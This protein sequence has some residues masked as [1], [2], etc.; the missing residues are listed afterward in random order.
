MI[1]MKKTIFLVIAVWMV[2]ILACNFSTSTANIS[3]AKMAKDAE[4]KQSTT[5]FAQDDTF[6][7]VLQVAN[8]PNDTKIKAVWTAVEADGVDP[9]FKIGEKELTGG[10]AVN[11]SLSN[12]DGKLWPAG[13]Y[14]VE[15]YLNDKLDRTLEFKVEGQAKA[16][17]PTATPKPEPTATPEPKPTDTPT[18][19]PVEPTPTETVAS[20]TGDTVAP[21]EAPQAEAL[22]LQAPYTH[23]TGAFSL[24]VPEGWQISSETDTMAMF[25]DKKSLVGVTFVDSTAEF[26]QDILKKSLDT[27]SKSFFKGMSSTYET[28]DDG[29][30]PDKK[31]CYAT[32]TYKGK[33]SEG[34]ADIIL[35]QFD[36]VM[37]FI[38][39]LSPVYDELQPT[40]AAI[41]DSYTVD[42][43][44]AL[45]ASSPAEPTPVPTKKPAAVK[46]TPK[47]AAN[48]LAPPPGVA[49]VFL[50]NKAGG[51]YYIDFGDGSGQ[52]K[53]VPGATD[54]YHDVPPGHL[55]PSISLFGGATAN[56]DFEIGPD[57]AWI[58]LLDAD[59]RTVRWG[60]VYPK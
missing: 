44:A 56:A 24:A 31:L 29:C 17:E 10:G 6:Y 54:M 13:K 36:T 27:F 50:Q 34:K 46:P 3:D 2:T 20:S 18:P 51:E 52:I 15:I 53:V 43:A 60:K 14:K 25:A 39:F 4:G 22:P 47:P 26:N 9:N 19:E 41:L 59:G 49:R 48:P 37:Y 16:A 45:A 11:F 12:S 38:F 58:I 32:Y 7:C 30:N 33:N 57:Q 40:W 35:Q 1:A 8:A 5:V 23:S 21:T 42:S 55:T 28:I